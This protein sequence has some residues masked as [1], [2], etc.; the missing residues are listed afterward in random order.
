MLGSSMIALV[1]GSGQS[2]ES[3]DAGFV[4]LEYLASDKSVAL[5]NDGEHAWQFLTADCYLE[6]ANGV[7]L[8]LATGELYYPT[9]A[10]DGET[11]AYSVSLDGIDPE[12]ATGMLTVQTD[13][14]ESGYPVYRF[15]VI[16]GTDGEDGT[17]GAD[18]EDGEDGESG[19]Q[20]AEGATPGEATAGAEG[21][22]GSTGNTG[23]SGASGGTMSGVKV[24]TTVPV[25][26]MTSWVVDGR[27]LTFTAYMDETSQDSVVPDTTV[28]TLTDLDTGD[29]YTW[30]T[31]DYMEYDFEDSG[32]VEFY[33]S[34]LT[35]GHEY[36]LSI[37]LSYS[38]DDDEVVEN[39][40]IFSRVF[41]A[42]DY[43]LSFDLVERTT[44]TMTFTMSSSNR[45]V[46]VKTVDIYVNGEFFASVDAAEFEDGGYLLD[47]TELEGYDGDYANQV[48]EISFQPTFSLTTYD[49]NG[50]A[51]TSDYPLDS[52]S[53]ISYDY[54]I[55]TLKEEPSVGGVSLSGYSSGY[56]LAQVLGIYDDGAYASVV[57]EDDAIE[58]IRFELY[59]NV[60]DMNNATNAIATKTVTSGYVAYF[61]VDG[62]TLTIGEL[63]YL[64][65]WYTYNDGEKTVETA[66]IESNPSFSYTYTDDAGE[67]VTLSAGVAF[68]VSQLSAVTKSEIS[69]RGD[70]AT[71][72]TADIYQTASEQDNDDGLT[73]GS[74][75]T[76]DSITGDILVTVSSQNA[77]VVSSSYPLELQIS[78]EPDYYQSIA[79]TYFDATTATDGEVSLSTDEQ[80][81]PL[82]LSNYTTLALPIDLTGLK[83]DT[84]YMFTH[85]GYVDNSVTYNRVTLGALSVSTTSRMEIEITLESSQDYYGDTGIGAMFWLGD[86]DAT[87]YYAS[88]STY[89]ASE[90]AY[91]TDTDASYRNLYSITFYLYRGSTVVGYCTITDESDTYTV[92]QNTLYEMFYTEDQ[93]V[94]TLNSLG[95]S[96]GLVG[97]GRSS[98][99]YYFTSS[100]TGLPLTLDALSSG[101]YTIKAVLAYDYTEYLYNEV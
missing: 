95:Y 28:I 26:T 15:T 46:D 71:W 101:N 86:D 52:E 76:F 27:T 65:A 66:V 25:V 59:D 42:D 69:F 32:T 57:D 2:G 18:G 100:T 29:V 33:T 91:W 89:P 82:S 81:D 74:G 67:T 55:T 64:R 37:S 22:A 61:E 11:S 50:D 10:A 51:T 97:V 31:E 19:D 43:G 40:E 99:P 44:S 13:L 80:I 88:D 77:Y 9:E 38:L 62:E 94:A 8:D 83:A 12:V 60:T 68:D 92:G 49:S 16:N 23:T 35:P 63:Y 84:T 20:G 7:R 48:W 39:A 3:I 17:D 73:N 54:T 79:Y 30:T 90:S 87:N 41:T 72:N 5:L 6:L 93:A 70:N 98:Y 45:L 75:I 53:V 1:R 85:I 56:F 47:L 96:Y 21:S 78:A 24:Q 34:V 36:R 14:D 58:S 4:E